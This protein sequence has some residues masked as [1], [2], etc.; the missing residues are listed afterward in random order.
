M[1]DPH[2]FHGD[3]YE[4]THFLH[5]KAIRKIPGTIA[6]IAKRGRQVWN[7]LSNPQENGLNAKGKRSVRKVSPGLHG[8][9]SRLHRFLN[10]ISVPN[11]KCNVHYYRFAKQILP[12]TS[13]K[14]SFID[15][16]FKLTQHNLPHCPTAKSCCR[17]G[18]GYTDPP[19]GPGG[20][21]RTAAATTT[22]KFK[23]LLSLTLV[24]S[25]RR[26]LKGEERIYSRFLKVL[27]RH[28]AEG[29]PICYFLLNLW[30]SLAIWFLLKLHENTPR[31]LSMLPHRLSRVHL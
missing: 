26:K 1:L 17:S 20:T 21:E 2:N 8:C 4:G 12:F 30:P 9:T 19:T 3:T 25:L 29:S 11:S 5:K 15:W 24:F 31:K 7:H 18:I 27:P 6:V 23:A 22:S 10:F 13:S 14:Y 28:F 16:M